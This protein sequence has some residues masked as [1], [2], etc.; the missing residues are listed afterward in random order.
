MLQYYRLYSIQNKAQTEKSSGECTFRERP[1]GE[2]TPCTVSEYAPEPPPE[3]HKPS[4]VCPGAPVKALCR[5]AR[6]MCAKAHNQRWYRAAAPSVPSFGRNGGFIFAFAG[7]H[8]AMRYKLIL[9][10]VISAAS[11]ISDVYRAAET[12]LAPCRVF[13]SAICTFS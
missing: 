2:R 1:A 12:K 9:I 6:E 10:I 5:T 3:R 8:R 11:E 7:R 4:R 13:V